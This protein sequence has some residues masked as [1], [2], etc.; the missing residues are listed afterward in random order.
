MSRAQ[1]E[2]SASKKDW[3]REMRAFRLGSHQLRNNIVIAVLPFV[4]LLALVVVR[5]TIV[6][7]PFLVLSPIS[8]CGILAIYHYFTA[9]RRTAARRTRD[10]RQRAK[11]LFEIGDDGVLIKDNYVETKYDW[12]LFQRVLITEDFY[13]LV[14]ATNRDTYHFIP[15]RAFASEEQERA[16]RA[17][18]EA[19]LPEVQSKSIGRLQRPVNLLMGVSGTV[20]ALALLAAV[21]SLVLRLR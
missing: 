4:L 12:R 2:F 5:T 17:I 13:F 9:P 21:V 19:R 20:Y 1:V 15:R 11:I 3:V 7:N 6:G 8:A 18:L 16:F 10:E 14:Y